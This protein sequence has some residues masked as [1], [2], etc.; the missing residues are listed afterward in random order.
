[1]EWE[2]A[3]V[4]DR[5]L[6]HRAA[7]APSRSLRH[8]LPLVVALVDL[9]EARHDQPRECR[10]RGGAGRDAGRVYFER[11]SDTAALPMFT[12]VPD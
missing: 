9:D 5:V 7:P 1:V 3:R 8:L 6:V 4:R 2:G 11:V 10:T 12:P